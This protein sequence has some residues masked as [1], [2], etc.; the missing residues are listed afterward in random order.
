MNDIK[1]CFKYLN[2]VEIVLEHNINKKYCSL[3]NDREFIDWEIRIL[4]RIINKPL[5]SNF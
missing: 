2:V 5:I 3:L 1:D 4:L